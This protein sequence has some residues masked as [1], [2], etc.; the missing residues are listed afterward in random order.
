[1]HTIRSAAAVLIYPAILCLGVACERT[2]GPVPTAST[3]VRGQQDLIAQTGTIVDWA[4]L[5]NLPLLTNTVLALN[6]PPAAAEELPGLGQKFQLFFPMIEDVDPNN[7]T[8]DVISNVTTATD[9][10]VAFRNFPPGI[11]I[12]A[13][14]G[15]INLKYFFLGTRTCGGGSPRISLLVDADGDGRFD[16][17]MGD[18]VAQ[19]HVNPPFFAACVPNQWHIEDMTDQLLRWE[20][21]PATALLPPCGPV[22]G[23]TT[24]PWNQ[25]ETRITTQYPN[26][27]ILGGF[28]VDGDA[29]GFMPTTCGKAFYD[30]LTLEN[31]T[32]EN[33]QDAIVKK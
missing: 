28:L 27:G 12:A 31:R 33:R 24:C 8:N 25:L 17:S 10:G 5:V 3:P 1:M 14:D 21:T 15:Q 9:V 16:Q 7:V 22:G 23:P 6:D 18:F 29:C 30:L 26:H 11:K 20:T 19:G 32:L 13:L 2:S 4:Q